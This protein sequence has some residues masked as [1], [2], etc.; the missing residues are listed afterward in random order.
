MESIG[1]SFFTKFFH[2]YFK[3][4]PLKSNPHYL[5]VIADDIMR[6]AV[7]AEMLDRG[8]SVESVFNTKDALQADDLAPLGCL[9]G[10]GK[11][12]V[13]SLIDVGF[14]ELRV[15]LHLGVS[16]GTDNDTRGVELERL[17]LG[18]LDAL[19][20]RYYLVIHLRHCVAK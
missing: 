19:R 17:L 11:A 12:E 3:A 1:T 6:S 18:E 20:Q 2:F 16:V 5:P 13:R 7:F 10:Y 14:E 9:V 4:Y 15:A 8:E